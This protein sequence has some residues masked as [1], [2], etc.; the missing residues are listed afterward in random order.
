MQA[1]AAAGLRHVAL[2]AACVLIAAR[3]AA[4]PAPSSAPAPAPRETAGPAAGEGRCQHQVLAYEDS[5][6]LVR[7][8]LGAAAYEAMKRQ[9]MSDDERNQLLFKGGYCAVARELRHRKLI[10]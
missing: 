6:R 10:E 7:A 1:Q 4:A 2:L 3:G 8:T 9:Q 5:V